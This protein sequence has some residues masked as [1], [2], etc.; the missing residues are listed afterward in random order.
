[1][2]T[3]VDQSVVTVSFKPNPTQR[4]FIQSKA[5]ADLFSSR[6]GEGKSTA[7]A[8]SCLSHTLENP[9]AKWIFV[10]DTWENLRR[11]TQQTFFEWF[12]PG[13]FGTYHSTN[14]EWT[15]AEGVAK[16]S[17]LFMGMDDPKDA[18]NL[19]SLEIGGIAIDEP[20][21]SVSSG[22]IDEMV[23]SLGISSLRQPGMNW[24]ACKLAENNPDES[25]WTYK[26]FVDPGTE[27]YNIWQPVEAENVKNLRPGYYEDMRKEFLAAGRP[28]LARRFVDG[29]FGFQAEG[30]AVTP[31]WNDKLHLALGLTPIPRCPIYMLWDWG[32]NPTCLISQIAPNGQWLFLDALVGEGI[33]VEEL[34]ENAVIP[35]WQTRYSRGL[36]ELTHIY[37]PAGETGEQTSI[38]RSPVRAVRQRLKGTFRKGPVKWEHRREPIQSVLTRTVG[39]QGL[40]RVDRHRA[41]AL[42]YALRGGWHY[43]VSKGGLTAT[44]PKKNIHSHPGDAFSYGAAVLFPLGKVGRR[45]ETSYGQDAPR[46]WTDGPVGGRKAPGNL[47]AED[48]G[49]QG[50]A[51][52]LV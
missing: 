1:M 6:R 41:S 44:L 23:M 19:Q 13:V 4:G 8:W 3:T 26:R 43:A 11:T 45:S 24:Y 29:E 37:D 21:P 12:R 5:K 32:H 10:R 38:A 33:G 25:H 27:G 9:G 47:T 7:L 40:V 28:D 35:L 48:V 52:S 17:V 20:A 30:Q 50:W 49:P 34:L 31:Q 14:K 36:H 42:H 51:G 16:G 18:T 15:W 2:A 22:G 39:G 46:F